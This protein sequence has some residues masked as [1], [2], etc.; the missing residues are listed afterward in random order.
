[1]SLAA[2]IVLL[3]RCVWGPTVTEPLVSHSRS[4]S[5][6]AGTEAAD[7][8]SVTHQSSCTS[9]REPSACSAHTSVKHDSVPLPKS[10]NTHA[11]LGTKAAAAPCVTLTPGPS[12]FG[13]YMSVLGRG[14][15]CLTRTPMPNP[16]TK[17]VK[18]SGQRPRRLLPPMLPGGTDDDGKRRGAAASDAAASLNDLCATAAAAS[19]APFPKAA[20][21]AL[22]A[23][24]AV[25]LGVG[26]LV[27]AV[28]HSAALLAVSVALSAA[29][30]AFLLWNAASG[31]A[32]RRFVDGLPASSLRVSADGQLVKINGVCIPS[33]YELRFRLP[34]FPQLT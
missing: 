21:W 4:L 22:A 19:P 24:L 9:S 17:R 30:A 18:R 1:M 16:K 27:L 32:L 26:A 2:V 20:A 25:G 6:G 7:S 14:P 23:L 5:N 28:V 11:V 34:N 10:H 8:V 13:P 33:P 12:D 29:V 31:R 15:I 3:A